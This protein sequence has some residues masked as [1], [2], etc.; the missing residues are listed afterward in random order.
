MSGI[1]YYVVFAKAAISRNI[2]TAVHNFS[3]ALCQGKQRS[4]RS[5]GRSQLSSAENLLQE[6]TLAGES[7]SPAVSLESVGF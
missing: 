5:C 4:W 6:K 2:K 3:A 1:T 7:R